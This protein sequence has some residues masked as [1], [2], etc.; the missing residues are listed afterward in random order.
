[1]LNVDQFLKYSTSSS[2]NL[3]Y[4]GRTTVM[5]NAASVWVD[6]QSVATFVS[7]TVSGSS[8]SVSNTSSSRSSVAVSSQSSSRASSSSNPG[9]GATANVEITNDWRSEEHTSELQSR[10]N[11]VCRLLLETKN[12]RSP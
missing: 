12:K 8:S 5:G 4:G 3:G 9:S 2:L 6:P 1:N 11:L 10:E 7:E